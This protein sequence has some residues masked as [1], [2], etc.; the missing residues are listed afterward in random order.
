MNIRLTALLFISTLTVGI[1]TSQGKKLVNDISFIGNETLSKKTL[2]SELHLKSKRFL[3]V[4]PFKER[5]LKLDILSIKNKYISNGFLDVEVTSSTTDINGRFVDINYHITE[6]NRYFLTE[7]IITGNELFTDA[8][9]LK[10]LSL[11]TGDIYN[12]FLFS[13]FI[14]EI[15]YLYHTKGKILV[16]IATDISQENNLVASEIIIQEGETYYISN[17]NISGVINYPHKFI[18]RELT[19]GAGDIYNVQ[20]IEKSQSRIFSSGLFSSV[21][22]QPT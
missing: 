18:L 6:G 4:Y 21:E 9:L 19:F 7:I 13:K 2:T 16:K 11:Q 10:L 22:F 14:S 3:K 15:E 12:P 8:E 17:V 5:A 1:L 20:Q